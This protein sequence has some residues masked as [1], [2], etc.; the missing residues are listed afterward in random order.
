ME[1]V[2]VGDAVGVSTSERAS[3]RAVRTRATRQQRIVEHVLARGSA[4]ATELVELTGVSLM[5]VHRDVDELARR[6]LVRKYRGGVSA[7]PTSVFES[8]SEYRRTVRLAEKNAI[9]GTALEMVEPGSSIMVDD[10][11]SAL[12]LVR[13]L[14]E[15]GPLTVVTNY[16]P[17][18]EHLKELPEI[19]L[20]ALGGEHSRTHDSFIA[21]PD[22]SNLESYAVDITFQSTSTMDERMTY[23]QEQDIV[24]MK[25]VMLRAGRRRVLM[26][27]SSKVGATSL[28]RFAPVSDFT[29]VILTDDVATPMVD[30]IAERATVHLAG[31]E[32][33]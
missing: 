33:R 9:A 7:Q 22:Q 29:D 25:R 17:A 23:H 28:H 32:H 26:M 15:V 4:S 31:V 24:S 5:T 20:I 6:G 18:L 13:R 21:P 30:R 10:S 1:S 16:L 27:D 19:R 11:T 3:P 12:A 2:R 8:H 14:H